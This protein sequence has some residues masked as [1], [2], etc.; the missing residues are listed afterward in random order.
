MKK[1]TLILFVLAF[2]S[3]GI[4]SASAT[5][6]DYDYDFNIAPGCTPTSAYSMSTGLPCPTP[7]S[8]FTQTLRYGMTNNAE[9]TELQR[10]LIAKGY[11]QGT[12]NGML[13]QTT[14]DAIKRF[15]AAHSLT[16]D[17]VVGLRTRTVLNS[18]QGNSMNNTQTNFPSSLQTTINVTFPQWCEAGHC[19]SHTTGYTKVTGSQYYIWSIDNIFDDSSASTLKSALVDCS[20]ASCVVSYIFPSTWNCQPGRGHS[21]FSQTSCI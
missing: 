7:T 12:P 15:Q 3:L 20:G 10:F 21:N 14:Q 13:Y 8:T 17:G 11:L 1:Y 18:L 6:S 19:A 2:I 16:A 9:V 4:N 5:P